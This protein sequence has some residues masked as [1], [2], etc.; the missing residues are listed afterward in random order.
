MTELASFESMCWKHIKGS[1]KN[2]GNFT[3]VRA[4]NSGSKAL[5]EAV[6]MLCSPSFKWNELKIS[7]LQW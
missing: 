2:L 4:K 5:R 6:F 7:R 3:M 1:D